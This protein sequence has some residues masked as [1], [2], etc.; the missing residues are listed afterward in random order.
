M[1][2]E[3]NAALKAYAIIRRINGINPGT[4]K[5]EVESIRIAALESDGLA[6]LSRVQRFLEM[7]MQKSPIKTTRIIKDLKNFFIFYKLE[8]K[9]QIFDLL[10]GFPLHT[11]NSRGLPSF[12]AVMKFDDILNDYFRRFPP[13]HTIEF[14]P[15]FMWWILT[16]I[17]PMRPSEFLLLKENC[18]EETKEGSYWLKTPRIKKDNETTE[19]SIFIERIQ[20]DSSIYYFLKNSIEKITALIKL[21]PNSFL[22]PIEFYEFF[23]EKPRRKISKRLQLRYFS[24][25]L[26]KFY[27]EIVKEIYGEPEMEMIKPG[28]TRHFAII[29][30]FL[31]GFNML[32]IARMAGHET[33]RT[34]NNYY[35]HAEHFADS[36]VYR[37]A[38]RKNEQQ[39]SNSFSDGL[40]GWRR[41]IFDKG[42]I[43]HLDTTNLQGMAGRVEYGYCTDEK[44]NVPSNCIE[45]C[46]LCRFYIF[47]PNVNEY[48]EGL[49]WLESYSDILQQKMKESLTIMKNLSSTLS[50]PTHYV[51]S[52]DELLKSTSRQLVSLMDKK[53]TVDGRLMEVMMNETRYYKE[54]KPGSSKKDK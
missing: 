19:Q 28:D 39:V 16:N 43:T 22:F 51:H 37:L 12:D 31:Q 33:I 50:T 34:Q 36:Y 27:I 15:V 20:I 17:L 8:D 4:I 49:A 25:M 1:F 44:Q 48:K 24:D 10:R 29:N 41:Y 35:S 7:L 52:T 14:L 5:G 6:S 47:K 46:R 32:S 54:A 40:I 9:T 18:L 38:Q 30:M 42:N 3:L 23:Q 2:P 53:A 13:D 11:S 45:D 21:P 26:K